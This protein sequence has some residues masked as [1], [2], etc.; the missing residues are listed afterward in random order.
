[1]AEEAGRLAILTLPVI[2]EVQAEEVEQIL[3]LHI[4][5]EQVGQVTLQPKAHRKGMME[6]LELLEEPLLEAEEGQ[7]GLG[8]TLHQAWEEAEE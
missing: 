5:V 6:V 8:T 4:Q 2:T 7:Q 3:L 1:M